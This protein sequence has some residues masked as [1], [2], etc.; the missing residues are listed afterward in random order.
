MQPTAQK[1]DQLEETDNAAPRGGFLRDFLHVLFKR[2]GLIILF[3]LSTAATVVL[4][5]F[6]LGKPMYRATTQLLVSPGREQIAE[7]N[8]ARP[9][10]G[11]FS[12]SMMEE[13]IARSIELLTGRSLAERV[14]ETVAPEVLYPKLR[15]QIESS[16]GQWISPKE[17]TD[18]VLF[19]VAVAKFMENVAAEGTGKSALINLTFKHDAPEMAAQVSNLLASLYVERHLGVLKNPKTDAFFQE[20]FQDIKGKLRDSE[21]KLEVFKRQYAIVTSVKEEQDLTLKQALTTK[22]SLNDTR[23]QQAEVVSRIAQLRQQLANTAVNPSTTSI[24]RDKLTNLELQENELALRFKAENPTL[25]NLREEIRLVREKVAQQENS[26]SYGNTATATGSLYAQLQQD[27]LRN[28][29]EQKALRAR[30]DAHSAKL[31][32]FQ[33]RLAT[34]EKAASEF[35]R[36]AQSRQLNDQN[37]R[38]YQTKFE[39]MRIT[40]AMDVQKLANVRV[41]EPA[42]IPTEPIDSKNALKI[43]AGLLFGL[44]GGIALALLTNLFSG[45]LETIEDIERHLNLPVLVSVPEFPGRR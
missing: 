10:A 13:Q 33:N 19:K 16:I 20:Q 15:K 3:F 44:L 43:I 31:A 37:N 40:N 17:V 1:I 21:D 34:L 41:V 12:N 36:L 28:E 35:E 45:K 8:P 24:L 32:E 4:A 14:V 38:L 18:D 39:E 23:S 6:L 42:R 2:K 22:T 30:E 29:T 26:K 5:T 9:G 7:V 25:R 27:L 11:S